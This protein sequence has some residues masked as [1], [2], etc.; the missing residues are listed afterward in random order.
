MAKRIKN[1]RVEITRAGL[2]DYTCPPSGLAISYKNIASPNKSIKWV[3][4][5]DHGF[6]PAGSEVIVWST[7]KK[8]DKKK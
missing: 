1:A 8:A 2:G 4:G 3:Q 7:M 6:V 5:S